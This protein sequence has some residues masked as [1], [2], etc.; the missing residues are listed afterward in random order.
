MGRIKDELMVI[1]GVGISV[2]ADLHGLG[3]HKV[4]DLVGQDPRSMY[5]QL[6]IYQGCK[7]D[8]CMLYVFRLAVYY[9]EQE[10][11]DPDL[12]KWWNWKDRVY[13]S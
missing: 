13:K 1:P 3:I 8:G 5:E 12:L 4:S 6:C 9:A 7:V 2:A 11:H 10:D